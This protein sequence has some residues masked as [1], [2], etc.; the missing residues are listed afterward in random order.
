MDPLFLQ[1]TSDGILTG[2]IIA[3]GA[4]GVTLSMTI[5]RFANFGHSELVTFGAYIALVFVSFSGIGAQPIDPFSIGWPFFAAIAA[6]GVGTALLALA[7]DWLIFRRLRRSNA[8]RLTFIFASFGAALILRNLIMLGFGASPE[9]YSRELTMAILIPPGIR[10][11][12]DQILVLGLTLVLVVALW[13][14]LTFTR[15]GLAM[16]AVA[17]S[18][19]LSSVSG[20][21]VNSVTR[22][23]WILSGGLAAM[24]GVFFGLTVQLRPEMGFNLLL[25]LFAAAILGGAGSVFGAVVGGLIVGLAENLSV[26]W[27]SPG[28]KMA[29]PFLLMLVLLYLR[30]HGLFGRGER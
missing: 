2:A 22:W 10:V 4:I 9:Y 25:P 30:P 11:M 29:I 23:T 24:A 19:T 14:F 27:I 1:H 6:A 26:I 18:P 12:P 16:R 20:I 13:A 7:T 15:A 17:E 21:D 28:Y 5:L 8:A 3:L